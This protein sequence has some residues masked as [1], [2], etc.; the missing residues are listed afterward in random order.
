MD[1]K[2]TIREIQGKRSMTQMQIAAAVGCGQA[3]ISG[4]AIGTTKQPTF[5]LGCALLA[6]LDEPI[7]AR[8]ATTTQPTAEGQGA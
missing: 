1:W 7:G 6:L 2:N 3:T 4:L 5:S 8:T